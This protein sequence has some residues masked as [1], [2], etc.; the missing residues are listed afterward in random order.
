MLWL[1][2]A[3]NVLPS[4]GAWS[5]CGMLEVVGSKREVESSGR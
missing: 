2:Q 5:L 1:S 3:L 4:L